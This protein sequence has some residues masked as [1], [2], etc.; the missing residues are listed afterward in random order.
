MAAT[1]TPTDTPA[2]T[3]TER[4]L[5]GRARA[6]RVAGIWITVA[7]VELLLW[8][9]LLRQSFYRDFFLP[10]AVVAVIA[11]LAASWRVLRRRTPDRRGG[12]RRARDRRRG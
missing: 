1:P 12:D 7:L 9:F 11:G 3:D 5:A 8:H 6:A 4:A 2:P 10:G